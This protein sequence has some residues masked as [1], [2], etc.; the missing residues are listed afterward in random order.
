MNICTAHTT[1]KK[2][3]GTVIRNV[4]RTWCWKRVAKSCPTS[5]QMFMVEVKYSM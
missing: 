4:G 3:R 1:T 5:V 2:A